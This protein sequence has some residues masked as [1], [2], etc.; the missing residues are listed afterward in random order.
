MY[1]TCRVQRA[2]YC[3]ERDTT[4][5]IQPGLANSRRIRKG[6]QLASDARSDAQLD[7]AAAWL[8][9]CARPKQRLDHTRIIFDSHSSLARVVCSWRGRDMRLEKGT[10]TV[11]AHPLVLLYCTYAA[12][13]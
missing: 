1:C 10:G 7:R 9:H 4:G 8:R 5:T 3:R 11:L 2:E 12:M 13:I 6:A